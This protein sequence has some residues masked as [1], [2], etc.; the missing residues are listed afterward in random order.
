MRRHTFL[1]TSTPPDTS[2][3]GQRGRG[4]LQGLYANVRVL[5]AHLR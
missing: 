1:K 4:L 2:E 5:L 3:V